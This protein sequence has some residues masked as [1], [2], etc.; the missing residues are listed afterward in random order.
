[1]SVDALTLKEFEFFM[2]DF[3]KKRPF[4]WVRNDLLRAGLVCS[5]SKGPSINDVS[6]KEMNGDIGRDPVLVLVF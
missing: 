3:V 1:M 4:F 5:F 2:A 6:Q